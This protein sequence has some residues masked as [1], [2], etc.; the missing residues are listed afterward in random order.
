MNKYILPLYNRLDIAFRKGKKSILFD[1]NKKDY[2]DFASG[3]GVNSLGYANKKVAKI[4]EKQAK[5]VLENVIETTP[6]KLNEQLSDEFG[7]KIY[8][9]REDLQ[10]VRS[11]KIQDKMC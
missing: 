6:F 4:I 3:V 8:L 9:K 7:A 10:V 11:Y 2:I 5:K 1:E